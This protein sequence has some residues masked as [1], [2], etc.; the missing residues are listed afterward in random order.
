MQACQLYR[1]HVMDNLVQFA[2][3]VLTVLTSQVS[4]I[5]L[6]IA[7]VI[8]CDMRPTFV[9]HRHDVG[10][11]NVSISLVYNIVISLTQRIPS[12]IARQNGEV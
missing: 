5:A 3:V 10:V 7:E 1:P 12:R 11:W 9:A 6:I 2:Y 4:T 8:S